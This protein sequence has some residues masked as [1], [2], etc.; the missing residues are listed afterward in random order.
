MLKA[1]KF[2]KIVPVEKPHSTKNGE[3]GYNRKN[4]KKE[5]KRELE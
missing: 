5:I 2:W 1:R 4:W 3:K